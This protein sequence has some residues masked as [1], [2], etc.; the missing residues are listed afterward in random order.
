[1]SIRIVITGNSYK[2]QVPGCEFYML[3]FTARLSSPIYKW[4]N[5]GSGRRSSLPKVSQLRRRAG[6]LT[7][8]SWPESSFNPCTEGPIDYW[9]VDVVYV[10]PYI[11]KC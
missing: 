6:I 2:C 5:W 1:M 10:S 8:M 3:H 7:Q 9:G 4:G 11:L